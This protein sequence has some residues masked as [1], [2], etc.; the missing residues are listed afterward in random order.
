MGDILDAL[1]ALSPRLF[2]NLVFDV[3]ASIGLQNLVWRTPGAD[4]GRDLEAEYRRTDWTGHVVTERWYI[5]CKRY[6]NSVD[7]PTIHNKLAY[8][9]NHRADFLMIMTTGTMSPQCKT[10]IASWT[11]ARHPRVRFWEGHA[12]ENHLALAPAISAKYR[13]V[14]GAPPGSHPHVAGLAL[15]HKLSA[16]ANGAREMGQDFTA[17]I[18]AC[19]AVSELIAIRAATQA[20]GEPPR[21]G[22]WNKSADEYDWMDCKT[23][24]PPEIDSHGLRAL[25]AVVRHQCGL[26]LLVLRS[27]T[28]GPKGLFIE[29]PSV[30]RVR[31]ALLYE[32]CFWSNIEPHLESNGLR[33][34]RS[35]DR[36]E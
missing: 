7:W 16:S 4:Q 15:L 6:A 32:I 26:H 5:E 3:L 10:E 12:L 25:L 28:S 33:I 9:D 34:S 20:K 2:E 11:A 29:L 36:E 8:A 1:K 30:E 31:P 17:A 13:L 19:A 21:Y 18:E 24:I 22:R 35:L 14:H 23:D 27:P